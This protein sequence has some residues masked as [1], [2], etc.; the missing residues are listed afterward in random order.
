MFARASN[1]Y[2]IVGHGLLGSHPARTDTG[3][4]PIRTQVLEG[5]NPVRQDAYNLCK[6]TVNTI[7]AAF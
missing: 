7:L 5:L 2:G 1:N 3:L 4:K 6:R